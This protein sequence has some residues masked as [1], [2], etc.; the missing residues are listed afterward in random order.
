M[1]MGTLPSPT[2]TLDFDEV[3]APSP[4]AVSGTDSYF[5]SNG[6]SSVE[7]IGTFLAGADTLSVGA[8]GNALGSDSREDSLAVVARSGALDSLTV[9][10]GFDFS[11][12]DPISAFQFRL[13]DEENFTI[14][15]ELLLGASSLGTMDYSIPYASNG[16]HASNR[17]FSDSDGSLFDRFK[18]THVSPNPDVSGGWG[19]DNLALLR[20]E[21]AVPEPASMAL[22]AIAGAALVATRRIRS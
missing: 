21:P 18:L 11:F 19:V 5:T 2:Y 8:R 17:Y 7:R 15:V 6:I 10:A 16:S 3:G 9:G 13:V 14:K 1:T 20:P 4:G 22:L 12:T